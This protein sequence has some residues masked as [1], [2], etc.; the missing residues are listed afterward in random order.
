MSTAL[1]VV[2]SNFQARSL[3]AARQLNHFQAAQPSTPRRAYVPAYYRDARFD[4]N[5][6]SRQEM[7]RKIRDTRRNNWLICELGSVYSRYSVGPDGLNVIPASS[8]EE[9][10]KRAKDRY[11]QWCLSP[12]RDSE[13]PMGEQHQ[14]MANTTHYD[15]GLFINY[16][17]R[18]NGDKQSIPAI[19]MIEGHRVATPG[20]QW[21]D[22]IGGAKSNVYDGCQ[23][24]ECGRKVGFWIREGD[25]GEYT[26]RPIYDPAKPWAGGVMHVYDPS[27]IGEYREYTP[28]HAVV[29]QIQDLE[30]LATLEMDRAK[31][32][33][34]VAYQLET[35]DGEL[36]N[37]ANLIQGS[38]N[39]TTPT[40]AENDPDAELQRRLQQ[41]QKVLGSRVIATRIGEKMTQHGAD[42]PSACTQWYWRL[43]FE[44]IAQAVSIPIVLVLPESFQGTTLRG[45][46]DNA[47]LWFTDRYYTFCRPAKAS[48]LHF[49][50]WARYQFPDLADGPA[51]WQKVIIP[52]PRKCNVDKGNSSTSMLA[53][54][55]AGTMP[56]AHIAGDRGFTEDELIISK[57]RGVAKIKKICAEVSKATGQEVL[58]SEICAP[59]AQV[60][61]QLAAAEQSSALAEQ[62]EASA[63]M[64]KQ[65]ED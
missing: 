62:A 36:P 58:P 18:K 31:E 2:G 39:N 12:S 42:S 33:A 27:R 45:V 6:Y 30:I 34:S 60:I 23:L 11:D 64:A 7:A 61:Q 19:Q 4:A 9:W 63:G 57:A 20:N 14:L 49:I 15:G 8:D 35:V 54:Y 5:H 52:Q 10:N 50:S 43:Q 41:Y 25:D 3:A 51:D 46:L 37:A 22:M 55:A 59:M 16:C 28:Y 13:L 17:N 53:E 21:S 29:N 48:Y 65:N 1:Q 47:N 24:D 32:N 56:L 38:F 26:F 44:Q 40:G